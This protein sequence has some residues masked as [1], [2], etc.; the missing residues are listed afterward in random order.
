MSSRII[1][2]E[3]EIVFIEDFDFIIDELDS[4]KGMYLSSGTEYPGRY[5]RWDIGFINPPLEITAKDNIVFV[6]ALNPKGAVILK[7]IDAQLKGT[8]DYKIKEK[9][10]TSMQFEIAPSEKT[11]SEE[12]RSKKPSIFS[13]LR[14]LLKLFKVEGDDFSGF[15]GSFGY[16]LLFEFEPIILKHKRDI[17]ENLLH[18]YLPDKIYISDR[19][20]EKS[21][22]LNYD[23]ANENYNTIDSSCEAFDVSTPIFVDKD[24]YKISTDMTDE[25]Y[26]HLV[27]KSKEKMLV[28]DIF[29]LVLHREFFTEYKGKPSFIFKKMLDINPSPYQFFCQ[30]GEMQ[31]IGA[32]PEMFIRVTGKRVESCPISGTIKRG[33]DAIE[34]SEKIK[35]LINSEKDEVE[36]TMCTDVD[37]NDKS[38]ICVPGSVKILGRRQIEKYKGLFHTVDHVEGTLRDDIDGIDAFLSH[39]W[40]VTLMGAP[41]TNASELIEAFEKAPRGYYGGAIGALLFNGNINTGITIRTVHLKDGIAKYP[42]GASLVYDSIPAEEALET[43]TKSNSFFK[44]LDCEKEVAQATVNTKIGQ[45]LKVV[46]IDNKDSFVNT[47]SDYFRQTGANVVTYRSGV[48]INDILKESPDLVLHSPG[49]GRPKDLKVPEIVLELSKHPHIHQFGVCLGLQGMVEAFGGEL[50][51]MQTPRHGKKWTIEHNSQGIFQ[52][53]LSPCSVGAYHSLTAIAE[54]MPNCLEVTARTKD[55]GI[56]MA[57]KHKTLPLSAVQFHPESIMSL[58]KGIGFTMIENV[59]KGIKNKC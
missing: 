15:Y 50:M 59:I 12:N 55:S 8:N 4:Q 45:G 19:R 35:S 1:K 57:I 24:K 22:I 43:R 53:I 29:E 28:G 54:K 48:A 31:L 42:V 21:F 37:R 36:L 16:D 2:T 33:S 7:I 9:N 56:I 3:E 52:N 51:V 27:E 11:F 40:A 6:N 44:I 38:R 23:F 14:D 39:M 34:D 49:P 47:L 30:L 20:K 18:L 5:S 13:V 46:V 26:A 10:E 58:E 41:K 17:K 32:S 25:E